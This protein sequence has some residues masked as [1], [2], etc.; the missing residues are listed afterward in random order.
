MAHSV[1]KNIYELISE[2][3]H[4]AEWTAADASPQLI[5]SIVAMQRQL[6]HW[7][8]HWDGVWQDEAK[9]AQMQKEAKLWS[10]T[11]IESSGLLQET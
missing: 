5:Q 11:M 10:D 3:Q 1:K 2:R 6:A 9:K 7:K 4:F 8:L